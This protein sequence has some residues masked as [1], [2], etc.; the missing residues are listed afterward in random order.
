MKVL[1]RLVPRT[2][3]AQ[4]TCIVIAAVLIWDAALGTGVDRDALV[5]AFVRSG[6]DPLR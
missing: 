3:A 2:I 5:L 1:H 4:I 6:E